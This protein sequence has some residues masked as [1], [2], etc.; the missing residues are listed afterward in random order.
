MPQDLNKL[1]CLFDNEKE[2]E[3]FKKELKNIKATLDL[4][5]TVYPGLDRSKFD[6]II[7]DYLESVKHIPLTYSEAKQ[8]LQEPPSVLNLDSRKSLD[9]FKTEFQNIVM[10]IIYILI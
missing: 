2:K 5:K 9:E 8:P 10:H 6:G 7:N 1:S 4:V 3:Q